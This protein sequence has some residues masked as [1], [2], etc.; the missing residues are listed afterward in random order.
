MTPACAGG[1]LDADGLVGL[2]ADRL[3]AEHGLAGL[4]GGDRDLLVQHVRRGDVD[5]VDVGV[6]D[7]GL[8]GGRGLAEP[9]P[10]D[11][12]LLAAR[13]V[14]AADDELGV[15]GALREQRRD[16]GRR[17]GMG[18]AHP[19]EADHADAERWTSHVGVPPAAL[20]QQ[21]RF[22]VVG[23]GHVVG[24]HHPAGDERTCSVAAAGALGEIEPADQ[25]VTERAAEG[26]ARSE[27]ADELDLERG[28]ELAGAVG[29]RDEHAVGAE[30]DERGLDA[31][32][33]QPVGRLVGVGGADGHLALGAVADDDGDLVEQRCDLLGGDGGRRPEHRPPV[34]VEHRVRCAAPGRRAP[35]GSWSGWAPRRRTSRGSRARRRRGPRRGRDRRR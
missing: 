10:V 26:V 21:Q 35:C 29:E 30:L 2:A 22:D 32:G 12:L 34:E 11:R 14:V 7:H 13:H 31:V 4:R 20:R 5:D 17:A 18:L 3:L 1:G 6:L 9:E 15:E 25:R 33:E 27:A 23:V 16:A 8:P 24:A 19:A 28:D